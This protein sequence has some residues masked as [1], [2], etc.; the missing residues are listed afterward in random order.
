MAMQDLHEWQDVDG[1]QRGSHQDWVN[2]LQYGGRSNT[3]RLTSFIDHLEPWT[4]DGGKGKA[5]RDPDLI[6][7]VQEIANIG[8]MQATAPCN[9][10]SLQIETAEHFLSVGQQMLAAWD[11]PP[12]LSRAAGR[13]EDDDEDEDDDD[14]DDMAD[15]GV[16][17]PGIVHRA[18]FIRALPDTPEG[19]D[20]KMELP[21]CI[22]TASEADRL[23]EKIREKEAWLVRQSHQDARDKEVGCYRDYGHLVKLH[24]EEDP[25]RLLGGAKTT[26]LPFFLSLAHL[27][28]DASS[29][30]AGRLNFLGSVARV[31]PNIS[32][33]SP[34]SLE[35]QK[36]YQSRGRRQRGNESSDDGE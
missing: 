31:V 32:D 4:N 11:K 29:A 3:D 25:D 8:V 15:T 9:L 6:N 16:E 17:E 22:R 30:G 21:Y 5:R 2:V 34:P 27:L 23:R 26:I 1:A 12:A 7:L 24:R 33:G 14:F 28:V 10:M 19:F 20:A 18:K 35:D 36:R 13:F